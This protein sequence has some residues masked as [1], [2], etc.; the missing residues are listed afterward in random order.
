MGTRVTAALLPGAGA[1]S[2]Y[3]M[4]Y[5]VWLHLSSCFCVTFDRTENYIITV[6]WFAVV[7]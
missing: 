5:K 4:H 2:E 3:D 6:W 1:I 7:L